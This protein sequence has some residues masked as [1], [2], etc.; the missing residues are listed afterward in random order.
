MVD[1]N[2]IVDETAIVEET[3][4]VNEIALVNGNTMVYEKLASKC[5]RSPKYITNTINNPDMYS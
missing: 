5:T 4:I 2:A 3:T 1:E